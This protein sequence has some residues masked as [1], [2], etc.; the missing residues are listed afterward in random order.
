MAYAATVVEVFIASPSDVELERE[1][2]RAVIAQQNAIYSRKEKVLLQPV[3]WETHS[4]PD[5]SGR[6][7]QMINDRLLANADFAG[8][9]FLDESWNRNRPG[10]K[11]NY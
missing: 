6:P 4:A 8:R 1:V 7:Q 3:G 11:W 9:Y 10:R 2:V 5:L